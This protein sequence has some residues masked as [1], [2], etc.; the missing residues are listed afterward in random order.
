M[1]QQA[2]KVCLNN[3]GLLT[4]LCICVCFIFACHEEKSNLVG[5]IPLTDKDSS[6]RDIFTKVEEQP[7]YKGGLSA[8]YTYVISDMRYPLE[9]R[10]SGVEGIVHIQFDIER[11]GSI[12]NVNAISGIGLGCDQEAVRV[13]KKAPSFIAGSQRGRTVKTTMLM[14]I[15]FTLNPEKRNP[16]NSIQG[17]I[18]A[19]KLVSQNKELNLKA[20]YTNGAW[21]GTVLSAEG[22]KLAGVNIVVAGTSYG[23]VSD[24]DGTFSVKTERDQ[25]L[26][27]SYV[28]YKDVVLKEQ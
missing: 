9:A 22:K 28:G 13:V 14:P 24:L 21:S 19:G 27:I 2:I 17:T 12:S 7:T 18:V 20:E 8:F 23:T 25:A 3:F 11:N 16:D 5:S 6:Q 4:L 26:H 10:Q 1:K 15:T